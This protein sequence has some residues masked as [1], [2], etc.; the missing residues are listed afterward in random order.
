VTGL[1]VGAEY[2]AQTIHFGLPAMIMARVKPIAINYVMFVNTFA[3]NTVK[4]TQ[5]HIWWF[6]EITRIDLAQR[7][8][9]SLHA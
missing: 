9:D 8:S 4:T 5:I 1:I 6:Q 7:H 2:N 3:L